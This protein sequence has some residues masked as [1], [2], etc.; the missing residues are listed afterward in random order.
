METTW[1]ATAE[2]KTPMHTDGIAHGYSSAYG[3]SA[4]GAHQQYPFFC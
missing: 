1:N 3:N 4:K 2:L